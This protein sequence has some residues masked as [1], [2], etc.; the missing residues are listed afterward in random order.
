[1]LL[2]LRS[3]INKFSKPIEPEWSWFDGIPIN[4]LIAQ[5]ECSLVF[6]SQQKVSAFEG[7]SIIMFPTLRNMDVGKPSDEAC[8]FG[9]CRSYY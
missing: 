3:H 5:F 7:S 6:L 8:C 4:K 2:Y 1:M 9:G